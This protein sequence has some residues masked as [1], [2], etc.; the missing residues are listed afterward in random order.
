MLEYADRSNEGRNSYERVEGH[1]ELRDKWRIDLR[2]ACCQQRACYGYRAS[3]RNNHCP[4]FTDINATKASLSDHL[5]TT[6]YCN[7]N[8]AERFNAKDG[9]VNFEGGRIEFSIRN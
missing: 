9:A 6:V 2:Q 5:D 7:F 3:P 8:L 4:R 1:T